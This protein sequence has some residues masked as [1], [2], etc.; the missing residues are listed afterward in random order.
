M[1]TFNLIACIFLTI[2]FSVNSS[3]T[4]NTAIFTNS[5][6]PNITIGSFNNKTIDRI[7][8]VVEVIQ[9]ATSYFYIADWGNMRIVKTDEN[10]TYISSK[11]TGNFFH[12]PVGITASKNYIYYTEAQQAFYQM[13]FNFNLKKA[14]KKGAFLQTIWYDMV[15][16]YLYVADEGE[17]PIDSPGFIYI[18]QV[19]NE[20][21]FNLKQTITVNT[22]PYALM[23][24]LGNLYVGDENDNFI[25][26][27]SKYQVVK[28]VESICEQ[29]VE[30]EVWSI[31][32]DVAGNIVFPCGES[33][34][35]VLYTNTSESLT[36]VKTL[37]SPRSVYLDSKSRLIVGTAN[38]LLIYY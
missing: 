7:G 8:G 31:L 10:G 36:A 3:P 21:S 30:Q 15:T 1:I 20:A 34:E 25:I 27:N 17:P 4:V 22:A 18:Y 11:S 13:D 9:N 26:Y 16:D 12:K 37:D 33:S 14:I 2:A 29:L 24:L 35:I 32:A 6:P 19:V 28:M 5:L 23:L 38:H